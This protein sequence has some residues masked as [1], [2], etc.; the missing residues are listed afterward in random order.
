MTV[1]GWLAVLAF[2]FFQWRSISQLRRENEALRAQIRLAEL[3]TPL[4]IHPGEPV[5]AQP[6]LAARVDPRARLHSRSDAEPLRQQTDLNGSLTPSTTAVTHSETAPAPA[7]TAATA[8]I[9][10]TRRLGE[11]VLRGESAA[12]DSLARMVATASSGDSEARDQVFADIRSTFHALGQRAGH[13]DATGLLSLWQAS[14]LPDLEGF[15]TE[16]LGQAAGLGNEEALRP[17]L[18]PESYLILRS[19]ATSALKPAAD[20]GNQRAI[21]ALAAT[22]SDPERRP[23]WLLAAQG[24]ETAATDGNGIAIDRLA[25]LAAIPDQDPNVTKIALLALEAAARRNHARAEEALRRLG[26]R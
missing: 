16:G 15:A 14:R 17:L 12:L 25:T 24:L 23:L 13:G 11:A 5:P 6:L 26:W 22:A 18:D 21:A 3:T 9:E 1:A 8:L 19:S 4:S 20:A 10:E 2:G 7:G